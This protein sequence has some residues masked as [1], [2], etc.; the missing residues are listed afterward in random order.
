MECNNTGAWFA[1]RT[2][3]HEL[4]PDCQKECK[5]AYE[6]M[7]KELEEITQTARN[8]PNRK[9]TQVAEAQDHYLYFKNPELLE[10]FKNS[11]FSKGYLEIAPIKPRNPKPSILGE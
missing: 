2:F 4:P 8:D 5:E 1:L 10:E 9:E 7:E 11:L 6:K 3:Y